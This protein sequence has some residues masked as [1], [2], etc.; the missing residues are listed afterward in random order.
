MSK[1]TINGHN[2][3][4][5]DSTSSSKDS[6]ANQVRVLEIKNLEISQN[7][8]TEVEWKSSRGKHKISSSESLRFEQNQSSAKSKQSQKHKN[9][10]QMLMN[11]R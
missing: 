11:K 3:V 1:S 6:T 5:N 7:K 10:N 9:Q 2:R 4:Q 8:V